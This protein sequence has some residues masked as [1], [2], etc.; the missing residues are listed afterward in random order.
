MPFSP[1]IVTEAMFSRDGIAC[2][3]EAL[4]VAKGRFTLS[5]HDVSGDQ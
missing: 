2:M 5:I 4:R 1:C 3:A